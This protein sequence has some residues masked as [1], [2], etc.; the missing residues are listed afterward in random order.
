MD[1][2]PPAGKPVAKHTEVKVEV[3]PKCDF[4]DSQAAYDGKTKM[5]PWANMCEAHFKVHGIGVGLGRGQRLILNQKQKV[6]Y[7][8]R[9][10][11]RIPVETWHP[12]IH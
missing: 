4:C 7:T 8:F 12:E 3:L 11:T 2:K 10:L 1:E 5:G 6:Q 9:I